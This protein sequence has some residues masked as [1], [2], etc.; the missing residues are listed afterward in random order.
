MNEFK[1]ALV[2]VD[3]INVTGSLKS[4]DMKRSASK[5]VKN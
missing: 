4:Y 2:L 3:T 1:F 5:I